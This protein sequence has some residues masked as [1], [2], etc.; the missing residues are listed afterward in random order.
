MGFANSEDWMTGHMYIFHNTIFR[1]DE[2]LPTGGLGGNRIVKHTVSRNNILHVR[3]PQDYSASDNKQNIDNDFD[4]DLYNGQVPKR[5]GSARRPRRAGLRRR[6]RLR[7]GDQDRPFPTG[8]RQSRR[9]CRPSDSQFQRRL[10]RHGA[11]HRRPPARPL[12]DPIR[13]WSQSA[14]RTISPA[15]AALAES[16]NGIA[17]W[18][19]DRTC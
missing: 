6:R 3:S 13:S 11:R 1:S 17:L 4:Y 9:G 2:W 8:P 5:P 7:S 14:V 10:H 19:M 12:P 15:N 16:L 18:D